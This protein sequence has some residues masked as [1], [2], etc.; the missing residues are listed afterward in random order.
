MNI[1]INTTINDVCRYN[2]MINKT[3]TLFRLKDYS[4]C[5]VDRIYY[6]TRQAINI[7]NII[8]KTHYT[9]DIDLNHVSI[10]L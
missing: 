9:R 5:T 4:T 6:Y 1:N 8:L 7:H 2:D 3:Q 10:H